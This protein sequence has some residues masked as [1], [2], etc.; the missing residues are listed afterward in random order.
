M[1]LVSKSDKF[2]DGYIYSDII[3]TTD[4][5]KHFKLNKKNLLKT[6]IVFKI[7]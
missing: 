4:L 6:Q 3:F 5:T 7:Q 1:V 2:W